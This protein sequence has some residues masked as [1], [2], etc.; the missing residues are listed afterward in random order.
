MDQP[1]KQAPSQY[2]LNVKTWWDSCSIK[3]VIFLVPFLLVVA[4]WLVQEPSLIIFFPMGLFIIL[5]GS[6][7]AAFHIG[8]LIVGW[9]IYA[10]ITIWAT[11]TTRRRTAIFLYTIFVILLITN[12]AGCYSNTSP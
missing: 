12:L 10:S 9:C 11:L 1:T 8:W 3:F 5:L 6:R 2:L 4:P 7:A